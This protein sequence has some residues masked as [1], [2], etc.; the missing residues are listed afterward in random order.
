MSA[1]SE[2]SVASY[3][4]ALGLKP[5]ASE[6]DIKKAYR[7]LAVKLHP[8]KNPHLDPAVAA[9]RFHPIQVAYDALLDPAVRAAASERAKEDVARKERM[10]QFGAKRKSAAEELEREEERARDKRRREV[11]EAEARES[12]LARLKEEGKR[13]LEERI[14]AAAAASAS[15]GP[16]AAGRGTAAELHTAGS[17]PTASERAAAAE[18]AAAQGAQQRRQDGSSSS[19]GTSSAAGP[20]EPAASRSTSGNTTAYANGSVSGSGNGKTPIFSFKS[21]A[22]SSASS[23]GANGS[24]SSSSSSSSTVPKFSFNAKSRPTAAATDAGRRF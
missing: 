4:S 17:V 10:A 23:T 6:A 1:T 16:S 12:K 21:F 8:D 24:S 14:A 7:K 11:R 2:A 13:R 19:G 3:F 15:A 22:P 20:A 9:E 18:A 5:D